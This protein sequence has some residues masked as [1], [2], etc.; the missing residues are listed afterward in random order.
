MMNV[1][2]NKTLS[3]F[4]EILQFPLL[5]ANE[6]QKAQGR[7]DPR[8][9]RAG[10]I[11]DTMSLASLLYYSRGTIDLFYLQQTYIV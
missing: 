1:K 9:V 2:N 5:I 3:E 6:Q 10:H 8:E 7:P 11:N 4:D